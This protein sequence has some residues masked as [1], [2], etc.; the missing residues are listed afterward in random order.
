[1]IRIDVLPDD[2]L[3]V[4]LDFYV[5][6][7]PHYAGKRRVEAWQS[8]VHVCRR[9]RYLVF[10]SS[11]RLNLRL[12]CTPKTRIRD[13]LDA[14][15]ALP[16]I[17]DGDIV[18]RD[19]D[20]I[21]AALEQSNRVFKVNLCGLEDRRSGEVLAAMQ[22]PFPELRDLR[23]ISHNEASGASACVIPNSFLGGSAPRLRYFDLRGI[24]FPGLPKLLLSATHLVKL[25][26]A[27]IPQSGYISPEAMVALI[28]VLSSLKTLSLY[29][30]PLQ[31]HPG[32][33]SQSLHSPKRSILH[34]LNKF[35]FTGDTEYLED[36]VNRIDVPQLNHMHITFFDPI[37]F[38]TPRLAQFINRTPTFRAFDEACMQ[39]G[40]PSASV[41]LLA[42][43]SSL[44]IEFFLGESDRLFS[45][46]ARVCNPSLHPFST[47][48]DLCIEHHHSRQVSRIYGF[49]ITQWWQLLLPFTAVGNLYLSKK[50]VQQIAVTLQNLFGIT[51]VLP[52]LQTIF[53]EGLERSGPSQE[54]I[55]RLVA[56]RRLSSHPIAIF[57]WDYYPVYPLPQAALT[58]AVTQQG[59]C[60]NTD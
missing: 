16:L 22:V 3:V 44:E 45:S 17:V 60:Q 58:A 43:S 35:H 12:F 41:A 40:H 24:S 31:S 37:D 4:I 1:M 53:V 50:S 25:D 5:D 7:N 36:F 23:F 33:E 51:E 59:R 29:F 46:I 47:V 10:G 34:P 26:L 54:N 19:T 48:E 49:T 27:S 6:H 30:Q 56:A 57:D 15:P 13:T 11:R 55:A 2:V 18:L 52:N 9:W 28:S 38:D 42:R 8:L 39:F 32:W 20:N 21:I 14:W